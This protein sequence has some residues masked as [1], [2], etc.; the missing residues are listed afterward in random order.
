MIE[1]KNGK[2]GI[3]GYAERFQLVADAKKFSRELLDKLI[4][5]NNID[6]EYY[7]Y[8]G[9]VKAMIEFME[10]DTLDMRKAGTHINR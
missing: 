6:N 2:I 5:L 10:Q 8:L 7:S 9:W 1:Y 4:K 3:D